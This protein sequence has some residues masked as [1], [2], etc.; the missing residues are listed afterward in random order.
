MLSPITAE[1]Y[2]S[3]FDN[4]VRGTLTTS[5]PFFCPKMRRMLTFEPYDL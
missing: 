2:G 3:Q 5:E 1:F 4:Q